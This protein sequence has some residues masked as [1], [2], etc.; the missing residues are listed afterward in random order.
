M[1]LPSGRVGV[2]PDQVDRNG[3][4]KTPERTRQVFSGTGF[5]ELWGGVEGVPFDAIL[6]YHQVSYNDTIENAAITDKAGDTIMDIFM[7]TSPGYSP[8]ITI[9]LMKGESF[10]PPVPPS[11]GG[12]IT[13]RLIEL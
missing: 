13:W 4:I 5:S 11:E 1:A 3:K 2:A 8:V 10:V 9:P 7:G 12:N 6:Y